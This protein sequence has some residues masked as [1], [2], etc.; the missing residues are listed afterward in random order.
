MSKTR[1][2]AACALLALAAH[3]ALLLHGRPGTAATA[4]STPALSVRIAH[5][6]RASE[7]VSVAASAT[8]ATASADDELS[9]ITPPSP[10]QTSSAP[11]HEPGVQTAPEPR[12][13]DGPPSIGLPDAEIP[14]MGVM[15]RVHVQVDGD[16]HPVQVTAAMPGAGEAPE[17]FVHVT[18]L[19]LAQ[20]RFAVRDEPANYCLLVS[21]AVGA[22][23]P[24]IDW[25]PLPGADAARC[26][27]GR[28]PTPRALPAR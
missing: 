28:T 10:G 6:M 20:A 23:E 9:A 16:G 18:E 8:T 12:F 14:P 11:G 25:L 26:L 17:A 4:G 19:R 15:V 1:P 3:A 13:E 7:D 22:S 24:R 21:F 5:E 27:T 2:A